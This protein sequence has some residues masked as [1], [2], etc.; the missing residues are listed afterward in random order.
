LDKPG[1]TGV[2]A[3]FSVNVEESMLHR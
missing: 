3:T 2:E 1:N